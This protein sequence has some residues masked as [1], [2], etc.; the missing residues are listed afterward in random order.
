MRGQFIAHY[1]GPD[2]LP[3]FYSEVSRVLKDDGEFI[4][5]IPHPCFQLLGHPTTATYDSEGYNYIN[6]RGRFFHGNLPTLDGKTL[7]IG[8]CHSTI[9][10]HFNAMQPAGLAVTS[11]KEPP[12]P[13]ELADKYELFRGLGGNVGFM[14]MVGRKLPK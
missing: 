2:E 1:F 9:E 3:C 5:A 13:K 8:L 12:V 6:S 14:I 11:V 7:E 4:M 10:D